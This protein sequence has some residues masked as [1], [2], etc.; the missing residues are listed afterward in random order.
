MVVGISTTVVL[1]DVSGATLLSA[2]FAAVLAGG[3]LV[4]PAVV[5]AVSARLVMVMGCSASAPLVAGLVLSATAKLVGSG[6]GGAGSGLSAT[7]FFLA[8]LKAQVRTKASVAVVEMGT[9]NLFI[10]MLA[11]RLIPPEQS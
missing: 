3:G 8:Q 5:L 10:F 7:V 6:S 2:T 11:T 4:M 9:D 1:V